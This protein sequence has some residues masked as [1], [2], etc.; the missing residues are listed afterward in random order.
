V[1]YSSPVRRRARVIRR[2]SY[3]ATFP[4]MWRKGHVVPAFW[5]DG[6][7]NFGDDLTPWLMPRY[8]V[9]PIHRLPSSARLAGA[10]S[11]LGFLPE[12]YAGAIWGSGL[13][14]EVERPLPESRVFAVR[15]PFSAELIGV[16]GPVVFGDPGLLVA[17]HVARPRRRWEIGVVPHGHH[18][19]NP[20]LRRLSQRD[21]GS[22]HVINVHR[23]ADSAVREIAACGVIVTT[24]LHGLI[25][26]DA[27]GIP[28]AWSTL[29]PALNGGDF[30]FRDYE[31]A[32]TPGRTRYVPIDEDTTL[33]A[34]VRRAERAPADTVADMTRGLEESLRR[35]V[36]ALET[37]PDFPG[38]VPRVVRM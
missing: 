36:D 1:E 8:G 24:S 5:W 23:H 4:A 33:E 31:A 30:K 9:L 16:R 10:G 34:V 32:V 3:A 21:D 7:P 18:R 2:I 25:T 22:V 37:E 26:A 35:L 27:F 17:R 13:M 19:R 20:I 38:G 6:H 28:A 15:G 29:E 11:I 14:E 12:G